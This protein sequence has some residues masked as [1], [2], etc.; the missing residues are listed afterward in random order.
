MQINL[1][2]DNLN[3]INWQKKRPQIDLLGTTITVSNNIL[4]HVNREEIC[5][6]FVKSRQVPAKTSSWEA[7]D[8]SHVWPGADVSR[9]S[10]GAADFRQVSAATSQGGESSKLGQLNSKVDNTPIRLKY[11]EN[12]N[13]I[14][15]KNMY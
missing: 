13:T 14:N 3:I 5:I 12:T 15:I 7:K 4:H 2:F 10:K 11:S 8:E 6:D 9:G 1:E